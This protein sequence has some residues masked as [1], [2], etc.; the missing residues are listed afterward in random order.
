[1]SCGLI[2]K[3]EMSFASREGGSAS[4]NNTRNCGSMLTA[5]TSNEKW[6]KEGW[7]MSHRGCAPRVGRE[8]G[9]K[10]GEKE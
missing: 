4:R 2:F 5:V 1:M 6:R 3:D 9:L 8:K 7:K 10:D